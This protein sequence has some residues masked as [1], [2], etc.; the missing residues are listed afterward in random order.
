[1]PKDMEVHFTREKLGSVKRY[2]STFHWRKVDE[3]QK[4]WKY[5]SLEES[6]RVS[7]DIEVR[8]TGGKLAS[9][10]RYGSMFHWGKVDKHQRILEYVLLKESW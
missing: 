2:G 3:C 1:M 4:I 7:K 8:F 5:A 10:R 9:F 6:W